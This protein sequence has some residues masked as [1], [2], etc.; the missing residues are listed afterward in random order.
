MRPLRLIGRLR[1][2]DCRE[3]GGRIAMAGRREAAH[4]AFLARRP[5]WRRESLAGALD[6][7]T[8]ELRA[9]RLALS[10]R[11]WDGAHRLLIR[12]VANAP[13]RFVL[14]PHDR[15]D[16]TAAIRR[17]F[18]GA[19][20]DATARADRIARREFDLLGYRGLRFDRSDGRIDW[21]LDPVHDR[22][23]PAGFWSRVP[24]MSP[25]SGD[26]KIIWELNRHQSWLALGRAYWLTDD[27]RH[28]DAFVE[29]L[30][31]WIAANPPLSGINW[32]SML[33]LALRSLSWLWALQLFSRGDGDAGGD[34]TPW[35]IDL[36]LGLDRQLTLVARNLSRY[37]S[38]N[39]H[40]LGEALALYVAGRAL[41]QLRRAARWERLGGDV[42]MEQT[43]RQ[44]HRDGG[45][46]ELS[47]H[48]H[49][50]TLDFYLLALA[51]ARRTHDPRATPFAAAAAAL[52]RFARAMADD[53]GRLPAIG[54]DDG[55]SLVPICGRTPSDVSDSL[56]WAASL[57]DEPS[58]AVGAPAEEAMWL[59]GTVPPPAP[60][61]AWPSQALPD[62]GYYV[63]RSSRGDHLTIDAGR[64][65]FLNGGH[66]HADALSITL[67]IRGTPFL[68]D[69]GTAGYT[70]D[71]P[72]RDRFR[73]TELHNTVTIDGRSQSAPDGPFRWR[74]AVDATAL[75]WR[76][77]N[78]YD[79]FAGA[80]DGY[81]PCTHHR[82]VLSRPGCWY[83]IDRLLGAGVLRADV[84]WHIDPA[85]DVSRTASRAIRAVGGPGGRPVW[86]LTLGAACDV[87]S[88][89]STPGLGWCAPVYGQ[90]IPATA[91]RATRRAEAPFCIVTAI[92]ED[93]EEPAIESD[94]L[95]LADGGP[96]GNGLAF[97]VRTSRRTEAVAFTSW[98][99]EPR[100]SGEP[101]RW[102]V[103]A[104]S[105]EREPT[106]A[107]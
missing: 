104:S 4:L 18:P 29:Q 91:V 23:A 42:L 8:K 72:L 27:R 84:H 51:V 25:E 46:A 45:H 36:L 92:V 65:G 34:A 39:T 75:E 37:F 78:G 24:Y 41:P 83:V 22:R 105:A 56:Q 90:V 70:I 17:M 94:P 2:M 74:S 11:D 57:L 98:S 76:S 33:E 38:P 77:D 44:I 32:A 52:A 71:A 26:H 89:S 14:A 88:R 100:G 80:H 58:L 73:S 60:A 30:A 93:D 102:T 64:H 99:G 13:A 48:Y 10:R 82:T 87:V 86:L 67:T 50:Y 103:A 101:A 53:S 96:G 79:L 49:R 9:I 47:T 61:P 106:C 1:S 28:R 81:R 19:A 68:I 66:A 7:G 59:T 69:P 54:D 31:A 15:A 43:A 107:G 40:L 85:W 97:V 16:R 21:H 63:S 3:I 6:D 20:A 55:G 5:Q 95:V 12:H 62:T 35:T